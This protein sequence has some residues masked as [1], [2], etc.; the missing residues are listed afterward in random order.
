MFLNIIDKI[1]DSYITNL[2]LELIS[3]NKFNIDIYINKL[4]FK[5]IKDIIKDNN[6]VITIEKIITNYIYIY[7]LLYKYYD[8]SKDDINKILLSDM[9]TN[10]NINNNIINS[11]N[12][13]VDIKNDL[14][15]LKNNNYNKDLNIYN[16]HEFI[17]NINIDYYKANITK[18]TNLL[19]Y[20]MINILYFN[21]DKYI[22]Y[23]IFEK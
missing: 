18:K 22:I 14:I 8:N 21:H 23:E 20:I 9:N 16:N 4:D 12:K 19:I 5:Q 10:N 2:T 11:I 3:N 13:I 7:N 1:I 17:K 15:N 6:D